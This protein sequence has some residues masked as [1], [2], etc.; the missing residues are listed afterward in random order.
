VMPI[1]RSLPDLVAV[2]WWG[3][4][5]PAGTPRPIIDKLNADLVKVLAM[6]DVKEK[7]AGLGVE[8]VSSTPEQFAAFIQTEAARYGKLIRE[9]NITAAQ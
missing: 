1:A 8:P 2:N 9:A 7:F 3:V 6:P 5:V 4:L